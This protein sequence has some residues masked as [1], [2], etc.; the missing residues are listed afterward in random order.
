MQSMPWRSTHYVFWHR[1]GTRL[2]GNREKAGEEEGSITADPFRGN[3]KTAVGSPFMSENSVHEDQP[4]VAAGKFGRKV[5]KEMIERMRQYRQTGMS[6]PEIN[7]HLM[8]PISTGQRYVKDV[9]VNKPADSPGP[10]KL[11]EAPA[12]PLRQ[13]EPKTN[14]VVQR[15]VATGEPS[16]S[17]VQGVLG[18]QAAVGNNGGTKT[19]VEAQREQKYVDQN[20]AVETTQIVVKW[21]PNM[22]LKLQARMDGTGYKVIGDWW[23][24]YA[25]PRLLA[26]EE[27]EEYIDFPE[28]TEGDARTR[29]RKWVHVFQTHMDNSLKYL[30]ALDELKKDAVRRQLGR[31]NW[32]E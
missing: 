9:I 23:D 2:R 5:N 1:G 3:S 10:S 14:I 26:M 19:I 21:S 24:Q 12:A 28:A 22:I 29:I 8:V 18:P 16:D 6:I 11:G 13:A 15:E 20:V 30:Q 31:A 7:W 32:S 4:R 27:A 25:I 17:A